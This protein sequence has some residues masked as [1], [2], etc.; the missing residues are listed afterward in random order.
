MNL[1]KISAEGSPKSKLIYHEDFDVLHVNTMEDHAYFI[2]FSKTQNPFERRENS[3]AFFLLN[4][5]WDFKYYD[6]AIDLEDDFI[7]A[8]FE[9]KIPVPSCWQ[10]YGYDK[11][12]YT[13]L[14]YPIPYDPPY[15]P[16][17]VPVGVYKTGYEYKA[18]G[19]R[20]IL[21][22]EGVDSNLY[23]FINHDFVG[24]SQVSHHTSE[25][26][27]T[28]YLSEGNNE[29][30]VAVFKWCDATYVEDQDKIRLSGIFRD[31]YILSRPQNR[32]TDFRIHTYQKKND[33]EL[34]ITVFGKDCDF[35]LFDADDNEIM[36]GSIKAGSTVKGTVS[37]PFMWSAED[38]YLYKLVLEDDAEKIGEKVGFR[39]ISVKNMVLLLNGKPIKF[40]G[41]NRHDSYPD[42]GYV[43]TYDKMRN[44]LLAMKKFNINAV[45]TSHYPNAPM[46]YKL[47]DELGLYV[48]AEADVEA[49]GCVATFNNLHWNEPNAYRKIS[50][51][52]CDERFKKSITDREKLLVVTNY[53]RPSI[54][55][56]S[57]GNETGWGVNMYEGAK[58]VKALDS[59]RIL[60]YEGYVHRFDDEYPHEIL[61]ISS[62]MYMSTEEMKTFFDEA[63]ENRPLVLC[64]YC[65]AM[66]N[67]PGDL[68]DYFEAFDSDERIAGGLIW[69]WCDHSV[70]LG[71]TSDGRVKYGYGGD[72]GEKHNDGNFCLDGLNYPDRTP[73]TGLY[74]VKQVY[75]PVRVMK[76]NNDNEF[77]IRNMLSFINAE[78]LFDGRYEITSDGY[79]SQMYDFDFK[80]GPL[81]ETIIKINDLPADSDNTYYIRF[82]FTYKNDM[83]WAEKGSEACFDQLK[84]FDGKTVR[85]E[86][87]G[88]KVKLSRSPLFIKIEAGDCEY[89]FNVRTAAF[90]YIKCGGE[91]MINKPL[92][93]NFFRAPTDNDSKRGDWFN[94]HLNDF[95]VKVHDVNITQAP[96]RV[97]IEAER[98][99]GWSMHLPFAVMNVKYTVYG[100][101]TLD[102]NCDVKTSDRVLEMLPRFGLRLFVPKKLDT[103]SYYGYG[104]LE[105]YIDKHRASYVGNF[106]EKIENMHEDYI[107]PQENSSHFGC[108]S[109][110]VEGAGKKLSFSTSTDFSFNASEYTEEELSSKKHNYELEKD[111]NNVICVDYKMAGVGSNSCGPALK[112]KYRLP[113]PDFTADFRIKPSIV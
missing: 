60:H 45:R 40:R 63:K 101:G 32:I 95:T 5:E 13:N 18:D 50:T 67:G 16:D 74:E 83:P 8:K 7:A 11:P 64:E 100:D 69:E 111:E 28:D 53:N 88:G 23:L 36:K 65:H 55:F 58:L 71:K 80:A 24:Y 41:V 30:T 46:F 94:A 77:V 97:E 27:I 78:S 76:G 61:D 10:L 108:T 38:P 35:T 79:R 59:S 44:D 9:D 84:L 102:V 113:L 87:E 90:D 42:T 48:I 99:F 56:W 4:K 6:S 107:K 49:H 85:K 81:S 62:R 1:A 37:S 33:F 72:F 21:A 20:K 68:E 82:I 104:P 105:S 89:G 22:F 14:N 109:M 19:L 92:E 103:V 2:P 39:E 86:P 31:V 70:P 66:G 54:V 52:A 106:T 29:I 17:D 25:F 73:H 12:Q 15:V 57:L 110:S 51:V 3:K 93:F 98:A 91:N 26:D 75:R 43:A 47:C 112:D 34:E 96:D